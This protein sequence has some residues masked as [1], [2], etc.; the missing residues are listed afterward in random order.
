MRCFGRF[1]VCDNMCGGSQSHDLQQM[2][3]QKV[4]VIRTHINTHI[5]THKFKEVVGRV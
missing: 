2:V 1:F 5:D 3:E 4:C